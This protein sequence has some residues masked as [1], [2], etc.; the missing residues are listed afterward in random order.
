MVD[1]EPVERAPDLLARAGVRALPGL[2]GQEELVLLDPVGDAELRVPVAE[3]DIDVV[4][5]VLEDH[6]ERAIGV[7]LGDV[8]ERRGTEDHA[9]GLVSGRT[10]GRALDHSRE[11]T[12]PAL[13][14]SSSTS[15]PDPVRFGRMGAIRVHEFMTLDGVV[16]AP[17]WTFE[18]GFDPKMGET[19]AAITERCSGILLGRRTYE[20][21]EPAW[22]SRTVEDDPGAPFFNDTAKYVVSGTLSEPTWSRSE[23]IG[24]YDAGRL[25]RLKD[26]V[27]G[28]LYVSGSIQL[29]RAMLADELIDELALFVYPVTLGSGPRLFDQG[30]APAKFTRRN[31]EA[32]DNGVV[33][34]AYGRA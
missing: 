15:K 3:G 20:M 18:Y 23:S 34:L 22:S 32:Y 11:D 21:F 26:E 28:D 13:A 5:A 12:D 31:A 6:L 1:P 14:E 9:A 30:D 19:L 24:A 2:G 33:Y 10:E 7:R 29:V 16:D 8:A 17:T 27:D 4:D 25:R